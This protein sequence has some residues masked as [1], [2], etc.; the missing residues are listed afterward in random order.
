[1]TINV[2]TEFELTCQT[3]SQKESYTPLSHPLLAMDF[4]LF[5]PLRRPGWMKDTN[6]ISLGG[7]MRYPVHSLILYLHL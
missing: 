3:G 7:T 4:T 2:A 6:S 1:M 5:Q